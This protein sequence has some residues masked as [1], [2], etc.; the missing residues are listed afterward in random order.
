MSITISRRMASIAAAAAVSG[1][2]LAGCADDEGGMEAE[3]TTSAPMTSE[4]TTEE[5][6][7][8]AEPGRHAGRSRVCGLRRG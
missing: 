4:M 8:M 7:P 3:G 1:L 2:V 6:S 5:T